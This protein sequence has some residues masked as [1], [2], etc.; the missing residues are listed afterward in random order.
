MSDEE[1]QRGIQ[2]FRIQVDLI[3]RGDYEAALEL[4]D[5]EVEIVTRDPDVAITGVWRGREGHRRLLAEWDAAWR[6]HTEYEIEEI[7][8][9][10]ERFMAVATY[11]AVGLDSG[12]AVEG[13]FFWLC[14]Y[15]DGRLLRWE[16]FTEREQA[17]L[18]AASHD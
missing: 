10:G 2:T 17:L 11:K 7:V 13:Q 18:A 6:G 3:S 15:R 5:P 14:Q 12:V 16:T 9:L 8:E 4:H 1:L